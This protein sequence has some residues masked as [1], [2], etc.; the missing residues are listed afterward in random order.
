VEEEIEV[1]NLDLWRAIQSNQT[2]AGA[3]ELRRNEM[4]IVANGSGWGKVRERR[5]RCMRK[6][7]RVGESDT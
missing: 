5:G 3:T 4:S 6:E 2:F 7:Q 1:G